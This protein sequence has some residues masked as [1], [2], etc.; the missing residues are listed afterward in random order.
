MRK[1]RNIARLFILTLTLAGLMGWSNLPTHFLG[2][3]AQA[4]T[5]TSR[6]RLADG[7]VSRAV[8]NGKIAFV[9]NGQGNNT[10]IYTMNLDGSGRT[11]LTFGHADF[12]PAWSPG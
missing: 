6:M 4:S 3:A 7:R 9:S 1:L 2:Q 5:R 11:R 8:A 10:E 12:Y